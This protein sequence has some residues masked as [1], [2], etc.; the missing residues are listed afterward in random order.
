MHKPKVILPEAR[1]ID[2]SE[3]PNFSRREFVV[4]PDRY[5]EPFL[6]YRLQDFRTRYGRRVFP[7]PVSGAIARTNGSKTSQHFIGDWDNPT[8][9]S[10]AIDIFPEGKAIHYALAAMQM[11]GLNGIG[12]Y[13]NTKGPDG[14]PWVM[15]H[16][17][18]RR[19]PANAHGPVF[20]VVDREGNY[21]LPYKSPEHWKLFLDPKLYADRTKGCY[22]E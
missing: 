14:Q 7:S 2:W 3:I 22:K 6:I 20:W 11:V 18:I 10:T 4:D 5:I 21:R 9:K 8:R 16:I 15:L 13:L 12:V 1:S 19:L 17:D